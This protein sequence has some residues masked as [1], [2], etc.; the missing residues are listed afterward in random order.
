MTDYAKRWRIEQKTPD[1][2]VADSDTYDAVLESFG[3]NVLQELHDRVRGF[4]HDGE[5]EA[6][7]YRLAFNSMCQTLGW[8]GPK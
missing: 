3:C 4:I 1:L 8:E 5:T 7:A 2:Y 6:M